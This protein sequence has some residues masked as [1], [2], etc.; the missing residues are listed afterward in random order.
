MGGVKHRCHGL[1]GIAQ[2]AGLSAVPIA[3]YLVVVGSALAVLFVDSRAGLCRS[4]RRVSL[5]GR[6]LSTGRPS[7]S[8]SRA[9]SD[10]AASHPARGRRHDAGRAG[11]AS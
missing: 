7:G 6:R 3:K 8:D 9:N 2:I 5:I 11:I 1:T 10:D 4:R